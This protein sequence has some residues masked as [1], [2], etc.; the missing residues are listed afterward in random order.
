MRVI[1]LES[2][3]KLGNAGSVVK[4]A[5]GYARNYL[6]PRK[7]AIMA[8]KNNLQK[9]ESIKHEAEQKELEA[10][11]ALKAIA[12]QIEGTELTFKRRADENDHLYGS[13][14]DVD[15]AQALQEKGFD[16]H[17]SMIQGDRH[18]KTIGELDV[19]IHLTSDIKAVVKVIIEKEE[20]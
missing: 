9:L 18:I 2:L 5:D 10:T 19:E 7:Y 12:Q 16:I 20:E 3:E 8:N 1:L 4:V 11:N 6:I 13:V 14:S 15:I 17:K